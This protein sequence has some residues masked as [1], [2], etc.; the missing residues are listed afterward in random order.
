VSRAT[1]I[2][3]ESAVLRKVVLC[4]RHPAGGSVPAGDAPAPA[5]PASD[6]ILTELAAAPEPGD[7]AVRRAAAAPAAR[8]PWIGEP[9]APCQVQEVIGPFLR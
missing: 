9:L 6:L 7:T 2:V 8:S 3:D 5:A 1:L 4:G